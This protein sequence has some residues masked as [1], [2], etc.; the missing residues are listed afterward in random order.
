MAENEKWFCICGE[1]FDTWTDLLNKHIRPLRRQGF[2]EDEHKAQGLINIETGE[3]IGKSPVNIHRGPGG[4]PSKQKGEDK[5]TPAAK[6][7]SEAA[8]I[9][10]VPKTFTFNSA[11]LWQAMEAAINEWN[12]PRDMNP[13]DFLD[14]F[15]YLAFK[16]RG[17]I[18]GGYA[19]EEE[20]ASS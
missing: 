15:L 17:I 8:Y 4:R 7:L 6:S 10:I 16:Q 12:W 13:E 1:Q 20:Y 11:L 3:L 14:T 2:T 5:G 19:K 18:L 9:R